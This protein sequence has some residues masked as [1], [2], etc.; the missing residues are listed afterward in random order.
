MSLHARFTFL[1][2]GPDTLIGIRSIAEIAI[3][4]DRVD[5]AAS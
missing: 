2:S 5:R 3:L 4:D 1:L